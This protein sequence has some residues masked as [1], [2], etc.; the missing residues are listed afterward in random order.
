MMVGTPFGYNDL[1]AELEQTET[2]QVETY[3]AIN[4]KVKHYGG[5]M[6]S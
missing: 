5:E 1:Y 3:P 4:A 2:F 6:E